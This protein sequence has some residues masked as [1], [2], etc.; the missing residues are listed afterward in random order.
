MTSSDPKKPKCSHLL[1]DIAVLNYAE[2]NEIVSGLNGFITT[3]EAVSNGNH[4]HSVEKAHNLMQQFKI[5][6]W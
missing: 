4:F 5:F 2:N 3:F 6:H 1:S